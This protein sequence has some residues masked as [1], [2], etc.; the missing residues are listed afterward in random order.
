MIEIGR[1]VCRGHLLQPLLQQ[2][3]PGRSAQHCV[4]VA[5]GDLQGGDSL[6]KAPKK[7]SSCGDDMWMME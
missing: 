1:G 3:C 5:L 6:G 4:P 2:G 7:R